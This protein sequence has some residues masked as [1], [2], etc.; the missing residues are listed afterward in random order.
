MKA[1]ILVGGFGTR[2]RPLTFTKPKPLI[3]L[4]DKPIIQRQIGALISIGVKEV[5]L[6]VNTE[7]EAIKNFVENIPEK[8]Q[9][10]ITLSVE[11]TPLGSGGPLAL[12]R[13]ILWEK[14]EPETKPFFLLNSD[15]IC[16]FPLEKMLIFHKKH[17]KEGTLLV[18]K[19]ENPSKYGVVIHDD[20]GKVTRFVEKPTIYVGDEINAGV[21]ILNLKVLNRIELRNL[22]ME[23]EIFP[24]MAEEGQLFCF[25]I[26]T[27]WMDIGQPLDY[28]RGVEM[29]LDFVQFPKMAKYENVCFDGEVFVGENVQIGEDSFIG[30]HVSIGDNVQIG[31][32]V[33]LVNCVI[34]SGSSI[35]DFA[36]VSN[37]IVGW[38]SL[39]GK[40][41]RLENHCILGSSVGVADEV[42]LNDTIVLP[43]KQVSDSIL[44][45]KIIL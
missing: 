29:L 8:K 12:A 32:G 16:D 43:N 38:D 44:N 40:W 19:V 2:L 23:R 39:I 13:K 36:L 10:K 25:T 17:Q 22:S 11:E 28:L 18:T 24:K 9:V 27:F 20:D 30:P 7:T 33:R 26:N 1:L 4:V 3:E 45:G 5:I 6:A 34:L 37:S 41:S 31:C 15:V 14:D 21:S 42:Y 35:N